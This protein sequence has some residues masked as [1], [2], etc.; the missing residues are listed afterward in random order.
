MNT[1]INI[2][3]LLPWSEPKRVTTKQG[4]RM[5]R[6][7]RAT[8]SFWSIW[9]NGGKEDLKKAGISVGPDKQDPNLWW[10]CWWLPIPVEVIQ[11]E[12]ES[13]EASRAADA[14][15]DVPAPV[16]CEFLPYQKAGIAFCLKKFGVDVSETHKIERNCPSRG[17]LLADEMGL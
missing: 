9:R 16:G 11:A 4:D 14:V 12:K 5:L 7:A 13:I 17:V 2:E 1:T 10:A 6:K 15:I 3:T 8:E